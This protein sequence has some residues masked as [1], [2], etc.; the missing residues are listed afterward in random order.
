MDLLNVLYDRTTQLPS[1]LLIPLVLGVTPIAIAVLF[2][3][4][5]LSKSI[6]RLLSVN[7]LQN[8]IYK[9]LPRPSKLSWLAPLYG[10]L[11]VIREAQ[12]AEAHIEWIKKLQSNVYVYRGALYS[13]RLLMADARAMNHVLG[14]GQSYEYPKPEGSRKFL[15]EL[16]G[17]GLLVAEGDVHKRQRR[18]LQPAFSVSA[19][20]NLT[21]TFF[22]HANRFAEVL[23]DL[24]DSTEGPSDEPKIP[25]QS[26]LSSKESAKGKPVF[27]ISFW[28]SKVTLE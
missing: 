14:Q 4:Y 20:R 16:L 22:H 15:E 8:D 27:D 25:G 10:D 1:H 7:V 21:P 26:A 11:G 5:L 6:Y 2:A 12:P 18:I 17:N 9:H 19:I 24:V 28:L 3:S 23:G 13:P